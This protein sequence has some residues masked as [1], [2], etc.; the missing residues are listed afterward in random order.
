MPLSKYSFGIKS[1]ANATT[2]TSAFHLSRL[3][4]MVLDKLQQ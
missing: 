2:D 4:T 1:L 3:Q